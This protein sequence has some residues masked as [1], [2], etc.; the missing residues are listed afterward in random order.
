MINKLLKNK[1]LI[2]F[3]ILLFSFILISTKSY[4]SPMEEHVIVEVKKEVINK[5]NE[6]LP[7]Y[8]NTINYNIVIV[9]GGYSSYYDIYFI[10]K[11]EDLKLGSMYGRQH[12]ISFFFSGLSLPHST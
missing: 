1:I 12:T 3:I 11:T 8:M 4:A 6:E 5:L 9:A 2:V 10:Q 7:D